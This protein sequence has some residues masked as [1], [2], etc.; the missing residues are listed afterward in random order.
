MLACW[1]YRCP[2]LAIRT[3]LTNRKGLSADCQSPG[4][5]IA[6]I[7]RK[8]VVYGGIAGAGGAGCYF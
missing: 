1:A 2:C 8:G 3:R 7:L 6:R 4:A 5:C